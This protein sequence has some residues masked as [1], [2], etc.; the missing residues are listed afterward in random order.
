MVPSRQ[1]SW[2]EGLLGSNRHLRA[3]IRRERIDF[4]YPLTYDNGYNLGVRFPIGDLDCSWAG[5]IPDFQ[6]RHLP[7][8]FS[9]KERGRR[10]AGMAALIKEAPKVVVSSESAAADFRRFHPADAGKEIVLTFGTFPNADWYTNINGEDLS[11]LPKRY[12]AVCNQFWSHKNHALV[13]RALELLAQKSIR[14]VVVCTGALMDYRQPD[15]AERLLQQMHRAGVASQ[16]MI[17]GMVP[18]R[19]Q[20]EIVRR[21]LAVLQPSLFEG[22]STVVEDA[23]VLAK[24][25]ILSDLDVHRE[26][27]PPGA[28][29]FERENATAL[30]AALERAWQTLTPGPDREAEE[31]ARKRAEVRIV[32]IGNRLLAIAKAN[33]P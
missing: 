13:I 10:D 29:F 16:V 28:E 25:T 11:W 15:Y 14:P 12:F 23:R 33:S 26:Q 31:Q 24:P 8:L 21:S 1:K 20:V 19:L 30:A 32:E 22:W 2:L 7:Q 4:T 9:E 17:L 18:R 27:N 3:A 6:H 5:W